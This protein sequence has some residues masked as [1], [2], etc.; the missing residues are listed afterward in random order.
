MAENRYDPDDKVR[1]ELDD[2]PELRPG[3]KYPKPTRRKLMASIRRHAATGSDPDHIVRLMKMREKISR[4]QYFDVPREPEPK[5][6][7]SQYFEIPQEG[8]G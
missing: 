5:P 1:K 7:K 4:R 2:W 3:F 6:K 8:V